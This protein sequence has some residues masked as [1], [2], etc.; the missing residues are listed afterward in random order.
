MTPPPPLPTKE[1][2]SIDKNGNGTLDAL[3][4][5]NP[6]VPGASNAKRTLIS[7]NDPETEAVCAHLYKLYQIPNESTVCYR[8]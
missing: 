2:A 1:G 5:S 4:A 8:Q 3:G 6:N 7:Q